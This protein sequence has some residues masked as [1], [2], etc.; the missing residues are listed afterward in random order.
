MRKKRVAIHSNLSLAN[1]GFGRSMKFLLSYL[2]KTGKYEL[3]EYAAGPINWSHPICKSM[4]WPCFGA[5]PDDSVELEPYRNNPAQ[6]TAIEYGLYNIDRFLKQQK[7]DVLIMSED[8]WGIPYLDKP[9]I[10]KFSHV[11]WTP[12]DSLPLLPTFEQNRHKFGNLWVKARFAQEA[13]EKKGIQSEYIPDLIGPDEFRIL[14]E[15]EKKEVR[16]KY[17]IADN[18]VIFGFVFRNQLRKL[19]GTLIEGFAKFKEQNPKV[20]AKL[21]LHTY[22]ADPKGWNINEFIQRF[23]VK[24]ED[25]L[26]TH[27]CKDCRHVSVRPYYG[28][29]GPCLSCKAEQSLT[30]TS[31]TVGVS[32]EELNELYNLCDA[33][34]H[35]ANSGGFE[36]PVAE[37]LF[38]GLPIAVP[39][40][41]F[42]SNYT[43]NPDVFKL[44]YSIYSEF[45]SQFDKAQVHSSSICEFMNFINSMSKDERYQLGFKLRNWAIEEFDGYKVCKKI[46]EFIDKQPYT[47]YNFEFETENDFRRKFIEGFIIENNKKR[48]LLVE[49][50]NLS[51]CLDSACFLEHLEKEYPK[52]EWDYYVSTNYPAMFQHLPYV[53]KIV[54][55]HDLLDNVLYLEGYGDHKGYFQKAFH[56]HF[57][58]SNHELLKLSY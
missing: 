40:Y 45:G 55:Y 36:M 33:Y 51:E 3:S 42:G 5:Y 15:K 8:I 16:N 29:N 27:V 49:P 22:W 1:T 14:S 57:I 53:V 17:G 7:P 32:E 23:N 39:E 56:P 38:A 35:P 6:M 58:R 47:D 13:L 26:T 21:F 25:V 9:W 50:G 18:T 34:I 24:R 19:V 10:G 31:P 28:E 2:Y 43:I 12:V 4:P 20:D 46:E 30:T 52:E 48:L 41:S 44:E 54:K 37:A 11:F